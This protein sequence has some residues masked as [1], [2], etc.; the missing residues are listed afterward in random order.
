MQAATMRYL[1]F[2][3]ALEDRSSG[4]VNLDRITRP[5]KDQR[6]HSWRGINFFARSD[7]NVLLSILRGEY[8]I[9]GMSNRLLQRVLPE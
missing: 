3:S 7:E 6:E 1:T 8:Q 5:V 9:S 2:I 4:R